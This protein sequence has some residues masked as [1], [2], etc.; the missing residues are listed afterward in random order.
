M[1]LL[2][3]L[4]K[5]ELSIQWHI[6]QLR[7]ERVESK[8]NRM[9]SDRATKKDLIDIISGR[10]EELKCQ[11]ENNLLL[12]DE[13]EFLLLKKKTTLAELHEFNIKPK[14]YDFT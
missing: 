8:L 5:N 9:F 6:F 14:H 7:I 11:F 13:T 12:Q 3:D 2:K 1:A 10:A 4:P